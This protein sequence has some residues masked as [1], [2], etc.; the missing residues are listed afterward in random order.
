MKM[1]N[2]INI[3]FTRYE[4]RPIFLSLIAKLAFDQF[5]AK[6]ALSRK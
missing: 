6:I 3:I 1:L 2:L 5:E 4:K